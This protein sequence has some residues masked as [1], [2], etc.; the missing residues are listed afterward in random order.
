MI[1]SRWEGTE[2]GLA[3]MLVKEVRRDQ[4]GVDDTFLVK[5]MVLLDVIFFWSPA[6]QL[7]YAI[8]T[9]LSY[10]FE[11]HKYMTTII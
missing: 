6:G 3:E 4:S 5:A 1:M 7:T 10:F 2:E 8:D 9:Q 11:R